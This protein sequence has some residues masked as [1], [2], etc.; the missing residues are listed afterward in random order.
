MVVRRWFVLL[1]LLL[2]SLPGHTQDD[3][4]P[5]TLGIGQISAAPQW[6]TDGNLLAVGTSQGVMIYDDML[7]PV[8]L[9]ETSGAGGSMAWQPDGDLLAVG[10]ARHP[11]T[12]TFN[13]A[14]TLWDTRTETILHNIAFDEPMLTRIPPVWNQ[15]GEQVLLGVRPPGTLLTEF[16]IWS[17]T[18]GSAIYFS[19]DETDNRIEA[20]QWSA[21]GTQVILTTPNVEFAYDAATGDLLIQ[22]ESSLPD[23]RIYP[24]PSQTY[25]AMITDTGQVIFS[26]ADMDP[27]SIGEAYEDRSVHIDDVIWSQ[28]ERYIMAVSYDSLPRLIVAEAASGE[29]VFEQR[30]D[31]PT[32]LERAVFHPNSDRLLV[33]TLSSELHLYALPTG[34]HLAQRWLDTAG[35]GIALNPNGSQMALVS[36]RSRHVYIWNIPTLTE[37]QLLTVPLNVEYSGGF[38][39]VAWSPNGRYLATGGIRNDRLDEPQV[40]TPVEFYVWDM[41]TGEIDHR[42]L[43]PGYLGDMVMHIDWAADS[44]TFVWHTQSNLTGRSHI[45]VWD[46]AAQTSRY[47]EERPYTVHDIAISDDGRYFAYIELD[48]DSFTFMLRVH[49]GETGEVTLAI[50]GSE[51]A[52]FEGLAFSPD[53]NTIA[54]TVSDYSEGDVIMLIDL[55]SGGQSFHALADNW[56]LL[57]ASPLWYAEGTRLQ[58]GVYRNDENLSPVEYGVMA[59][60]VDTAATAVTLNAADSRLNLPLTP[61]MV[62]NRFGDLAMTDDGDL[63]ALTLQTIQTE[64]WSR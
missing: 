55:T 25:M 57:R 18:D 54:V 26:D 61:E 6:S 24:S 59:F 58:V 39:S 17:A 64:V 41:Q 47:T 29:V 62:F 11:I 4:L 34:E 20:W 8:T 14:V 28:D 50:E 1:L 16:I 35:T 42:V 9:L 63:V 13:A 51:I 44:R 21:D 46:V 12:R 52:Q 36:G 5:V 30:F 10:T 53:G 7:N 37:S 48:L 23:M 2:P 15:S 45:G 19:V 33:S 38:F 22:R 31:V 49:D 40:P 3:T 32:S 60:D 56:D 27:K 43:A